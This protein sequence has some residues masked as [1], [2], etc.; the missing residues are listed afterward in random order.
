VAVKKFSKKFHDKPMTPLQLA[1]FWV[2]YVLRNDGAEHLKSAAL[3]LNFFQY[4]SLDII[5]FL[6][7]A[8]IGFFGIFVYAC[9]KCCC[10]KKPKG[11]KKK[12]H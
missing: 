6:L 2:E 9:R 12:K 11:D 7:A 5:L 3:D 10:A 4:H 1:K 8:I